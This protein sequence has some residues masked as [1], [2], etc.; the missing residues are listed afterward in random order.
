MQN[1]TQQKME[2]SASANGLFMNGPTYKWKKIF[3][4]SLKIYEA[5]YGDLWPLLRAFYERSLLQMK[6]KFYFFPQKVREFKCKTLRSRIW[7][8]CPCLR[9]LYERSHLEMKKKFYL[10]LT[11]LELLSFIHLEDRAV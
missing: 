7:G 5:E 1:S 4:F 6:E 9:T 8:L 3:I 11:R 10:F 2:V